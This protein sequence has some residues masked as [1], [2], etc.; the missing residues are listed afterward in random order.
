MESERAS[1][2]SQLS[3][4]RE[5]LT[6][7]KTK[8]KKLWSMYCSQSARDDELLAVKGREIEEL[9]KRL[10]EH[11]IHDRRAAGHATGRASR[12]SVE[13]TSVDAR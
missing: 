5:Q 6:S 10:A 12:Y 7:E 3:R 2:D 9:R 1:F 11:E 13:C 4:E 8:Y